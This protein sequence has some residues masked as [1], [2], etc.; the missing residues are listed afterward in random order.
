MIR[1]IAIAICLLIVFGLGVGLI[2]PKYQSLQSLIKDIEKTRAELKSRTEYFS[3]LAEI[4]ERLKEHAESFSKIDS[5]LPSDFSLPFFLDF[6]EKASSQSDL[7]LGQVGAFVSQPE[8]EIQEHSLNIS[9]SGS[10]SAFKNF[11]SSLEK[12]ARILEVQNISFSS[13]KEPA[14]PYT[15]NVNI[16]TYSY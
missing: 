9:L 7:V 6:L 16:K 10:Y 3:R 5:A 8:G 12:S 1:P 13:T 14:L 11:L 15:F 4:S 2:W